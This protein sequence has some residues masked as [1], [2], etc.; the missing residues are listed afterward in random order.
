M[1]GPRPGMTE[2]ELLARLL[3]YLAN[4]LNAASATFSGVIPK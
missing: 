3:Y 1:P 2:M 4:L